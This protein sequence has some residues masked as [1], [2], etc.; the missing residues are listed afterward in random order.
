MS[1]QSSYTMWDTSGLVHCLAMPECGGRWA[2][3]QLFGPVAGG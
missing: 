1:R 3:R 2:T